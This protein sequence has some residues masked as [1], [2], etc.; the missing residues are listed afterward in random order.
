[1][2]VTYQAF[3]HVPY[4]LLKKSITQNISTSCSAMMAFERGKKGYFMIDLYIYFF[5]LFFIEQHILYSFFMIERIW[6]I[7]YTFYTNTI[8]VCMK[9]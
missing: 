5:L 3:G 6:S 8:N 9:T 7:G 2:M 1:M 4:T